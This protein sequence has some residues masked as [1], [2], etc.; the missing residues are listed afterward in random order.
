MR[1][2]ILGGGPAG[3][4][5]SILLKKADPSHDIL[6]VERNAPDDTFGWGVVFSD[7]TMSNLADAD[8][9]SYA[10]ITRDFARWDAI[11][12]RVKGQ[13]IRSRGHGFC[14]IERKRLLQ[15]LQ[16]R[17]RALG[18][19]LRFRTEIADVDALR[20]G[21]DLLVGA[22]GLRSVVRARF[23]DAFRP[24]FDVRKSPYI[25]LGS[26]IP[27]EAFT[28]CFRENEHGLFQIHAYQFTSS[29]SDR[30]I[31]TVIVET[32]EESWRRAGLD[33]ATEAGSIAYCEK[34]FAE[35]LHGH[36]LLGNRSQ[37][38]RFTTVRNER[39][40]HENVVL[41]GDA[42]H[43]AHFSIGSGTKMALED[44]IA[45]AR[46]L[47]AHP[48]DLGAALQAYEDERRPLIGRTQTA[49]Q[50]SLEWFEHARRYYAAFE[51]MQFAFSLLTRSRRITHANLQIRDAAFVAE[52]DRFYAE[53]SGVRVEKGRRAPPPM[54]TP[55]RLR[56]LELE[57]RIVVSPMC[58]YSAEDGLPDD[59]HLVHLGSRAIG[60]AGLVMAEMTD[61]SPEAR[62]TPGCTGIWNDEQVAR[63][64]RIVEFVHRW[65][66][67]RIGLQLGHAGRKGST[68]P[69]WLGMDEPLDD[70]NWE[71]VAPSP[72]PYDPSKGSATPREMT[73]ADMDRVIEDFVRCTRNALRAGF[74]L[75]E[76][77]AAHGYLLS[78]FLTPLSNQRT[79]AYGGSLENRMRFPLEVVEAVRAEWPA[80]K[81][82][83]V[84]ISATDWVEG[85]FSGDDA[86]AV[87]RELARR[88]V[89]VIDVSTGQTSPRARPVFGRAYQTPFSDRIRNEV[90]IP[91]I[92]VGNIQDWDQ[93]NSI[94][95]AGRA[96]LIAL[97]RPHLW[98]PYFTLHA[99]HAQGWDE[100]RW[101]PQYG[102]APQAAPRPKT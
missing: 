64:T 30:G 34:V 11:D 87:S 90:G 10:A 35:D 83:S 21:A 57:N 62:I 38:I 45:L 5:L 53:K 65:S 79:D 91:T 76:I 97:A 70:G 43:T 92:A 14:G 56:K 39:W 100:V 29:P 28:F 72:I 84:R 101:P 68:K 73:R 42:A 36:P 24:S 13:V 98:D 48:R 96:D 33:R 3:L 60:G 44:A 46:A 15:T 66:K 31:S 32:D 50:Q 54:F 94:L 58:Q 52:A 61:V 67:A 49:A 82:L 4:Y 77:H 69:M 8:A 40:W 23:A 27:F 89:D 59:W 19:E 41:I 1:I 93:A 12:I 63:W 74:D 6:V 85:G 47:A 80:D 71:L 99:A 37:W 9:E 51:P 17:A 102:L 26:T 22:D 75:L 55:F 2:R 78:S 18:V 7:E 81:P 86:V 25:W 88:G 16:A 20:D 95:L